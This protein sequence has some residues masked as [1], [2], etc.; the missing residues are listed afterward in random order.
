[1]TLL[2]DEVD[3]DDAFAQACEDLWAGLPRFEG[4]SSIRTWFYAVARHAAYRLRRS[5]DRRA[6]QRVALSEITDVAESVRATTLRHLRSEAKTAVAAIREALDEED[7]MLL[8]LRID[9]E[10]SWNDIARVFNVEA[11]PDASIARTAS[12]LR[13]RF[14]LVK[15]EIR[16]RAREAGLL[17]DREP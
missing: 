6:G 5:P 4:R 10:M 15:E 7:R 14:Q 11:G 12:R 17:P 9:R 1:V 3:A 16:T 8:V 2:R 13:K